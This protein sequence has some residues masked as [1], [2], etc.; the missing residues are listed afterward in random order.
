MNQ[1]GMILLFDG[2]HKAAAQVWARR[3]RIECK[4]YV[5]PDPRTLKETNLEAHASLRQMTF[6]SHELMGKYSDVFGADWLE[7]MTTEGPKSE[8]GFVKFLMHSRHKSKAQA[9][10][11][12]AQAA[13]QQIMKD[14]ENK[15]ADFVAE[16]HRGRRQPLTF[17]RL[18]KAFFRQMLVLPPVTDE[19]ES[20]ED[21]RNHERRNLV[22]LL[23]IIAEVGLVDRWA[24]ERNDAAHQK[25]ERIFSAGAV[26]AWA[27]LLR[28]VINQHLRHYSDKERARFFYREID[29]SDFGYFRQF[30]NRLFSHKMWDHPDAS[31]EIASRLARDDLETARTLF[32]E[33]GLTVSWVLGG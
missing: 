19:F 1:D 11:E 32:K 10:R 33:H 18:E 28:D 12:I 3:K 29:L 30:V 14:P 4:V 31:G 20:D 27:I 25:A 24:P 16:K 22:K 26:R 23:S 5:D 8:A 6:Y 15:L 21:F 9:Q 2:Q 7:Y 17:S 13:F